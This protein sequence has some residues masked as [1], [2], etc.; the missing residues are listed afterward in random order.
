[1]ESMTLPKK[2]K[3]KSVERDHIAVASSNETQGKI[4]VL[5]FFTFGSMEVPS[6]VVKQWWDGQVVLS[7]WLKPSDATRSD[8][9]SNTCSA[10]NVQIWDNIDQKAIEEYEKMFPGRKVRVEYI[11]LPTK[12][13]NNDYILIRRIWIAV[14]EKQGDEQRIAPEHPKVARLHYNSKTDKIDVTP[15]DEYK[16][17]GIIGEV[18]RVANEEYRRQRKIVNRTHHAQAFRRLVYSV[19]GCAFGYGQGCVFIPN[20][21]E[22]V[23]DKFAEYINQVANKHGTTTHASRIRVVPAIDTEQMRKDVAEDVAR[24][25]Q[26][27]YEDLL[28]D[29]L[30]YLRRQGEVDEKKQ[31]KIELVLADRLASVERMKVMKEQYERAL[32]MKIAIHQAKLSVPENIGGR[33]KALLQQMDKTLRG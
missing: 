28:E 12:D 31:E 30:A 18:R 16:E 19:F 8:A 15:F 4:G 2:G 22:E 27:Q 13:G 10:E 24:E 25:V 17:S 5:A 1:M 11:T 3:G 14:D 6:K 7:E 33:V 9:Y 26:K 23:L 20:D 32:E 21:G 29:T